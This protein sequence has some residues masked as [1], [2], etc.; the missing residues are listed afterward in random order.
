MEEMG[1]TL[2]KLILA[3]IGATALTAENQKH[4]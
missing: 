2:K 1:N 3:G 4:Y